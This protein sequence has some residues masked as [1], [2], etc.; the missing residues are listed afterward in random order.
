MCGFYTDLV[1]PT[2]FQ[3]LVLLLT[4]IFF[5]GRQTL[6]GLCMGVVVSKARVICNP[7]QSIQAL[8]ERLSKYPSKN[9]SFV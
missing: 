6:V 5:P 2:Q 9:R 3:Q 4:Q 1:D 7:Q 8:V